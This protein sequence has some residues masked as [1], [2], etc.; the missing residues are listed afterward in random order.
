M[1]AD[2]FIDGGRQMRKAKFE[3]YR[4]NRDKAWRWRLRAKNGQIIAVGGEGFKRIAGIIG[5]IKSVKVCS[6]TASP[7]YVIHRKVDNKKKKWGKMRSV[8]SK[9]PSAIGVARHGKGKRKGSRP[10][11]KS[12][13]K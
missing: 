5:A 9:N 12:K 3:V 13:K 6:A 2:N 8:E 4:S 11:R 7:Q 10:S 1:N